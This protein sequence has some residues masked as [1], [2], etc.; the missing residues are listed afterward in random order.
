MIRK[1]HLNYPTLPS[2]GMHNTHRN[3]YAQLLDTAHHH[4]KITIT[5]YI[6]Q[7]AATVK[8]NCIGQNECDHECEHASKE[9]ITKLKMLKNNTCYDCDQENNHGKNKCDIF[10]TFTNRKDHQLKTTIRDGRS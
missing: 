2:L 10:S 9:C 3:H 6:I 4:E 8:H 7:A 5:L 1:N